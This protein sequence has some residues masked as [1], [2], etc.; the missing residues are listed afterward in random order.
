MNHH[1]KENILTLSFYAISLMA[2]AMVIAINY[3]LDAFDVHGHHDEMHDGYVYCN[4]RIG[5]QVAADTHI[6]EERIPSLD[7][8]CETDEY[9]LTVDGWTNC[10]ILNKATDTVEGPMTRSDFDKKCKEYHVEF[11]EEQGY[12]GTST[13]SEDSIPT[14]V[15]IV[16]AFLALIM[17]VPVFRYG[18]IIEREVC[19]DTIQSSMALCTSINIIMAIGIC[20]IEILILVFFYLIAIFILTL[21][22]YV[23]YKRHFNSLGSII[24]MILSS[25]IFI[26]L[27]AFMLFPLTI[28]FVSALP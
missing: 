20:T 27:S 4:H 3:G 14:S 8:Y 5:K 1:R 10:Y 13:C 22:V 2:L 11:V 6:W 9:I 23:I 15:K 17:A 28:L 21:L 7:K 19:R 24:K 16:I 18:S 12:V 25:I 26:F